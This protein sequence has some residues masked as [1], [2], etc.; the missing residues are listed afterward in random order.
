MIVV[1]LKRPGASVISVETV[2]HNLAKSMS[3]AQEAV[4]LKNLDTFRKL[5]EP[6][7]AGFIIDENSAVRFTDK[8]DGR[9]NTINVPLSSCVSYRRFRVSEVFVD[10]AV[11]TNRNGFQTGL[12]HHLRLAYSGTRSEH[13]HHARI[14]ITTDGGCRAELQIDGETRSSS[15]WS[16]D[17]PVYDTIFHN[18]WQKGKATSR[19]LLSCLWRWFTNYL[20]KAKRPKSAD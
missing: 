11:D 1:H 20:L 5:H 15:P 13:L 4:D 10:F 12:R 9:L 8:A 17:D 7:E 16:F 2:M 19:Q 14:R 18:I 3:L 6:N